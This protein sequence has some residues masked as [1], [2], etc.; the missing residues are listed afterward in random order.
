MRRMVLIF[1]CV[2]VCFG[3]LISTLSD[4]HAQGI[5]PPSFP[6][7]PDLLVKS[8]ECKVPGNNLAFT[9][10]NVGSALP[11]G[12]KAVADV[13]VGTTKIGSMDLRYPTSGSIATMGGFAYYVTKTV[14][15]KSSSV[16]VVVDPLNTV[17]ESNE[18]NNSATRTLA[19]SACTSTSTQVDI[20]TIPPPSH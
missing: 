20:Y 3:V 18:L 17:K 10:T 15:T 5:A 11:T 16:K 19:P 6:T 14:I 2:V 4:T 13:Y 1:S 7:I 9:I 12:W 8:I